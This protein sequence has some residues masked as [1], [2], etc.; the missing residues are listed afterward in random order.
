MQSKDK[1]RQRIMERYMQIVKAMSRRFDH[2][3]GNYASV[4]YHREVIQIIVEHMT[5]LE[6]VASMYDAN[7]DE[8]IA[9]DTR[10]EMQCDEWVIARE[11]EEMKKAPDFPARTGSNC[12]ICGKPTGGTTYCQMH[13][14]MMYA[15]GK[16]HGH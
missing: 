11:V 13:T 7:G 15:L 12:V 8:L 3:R 5:G 10:K 16:H 6:E 1:E 4:A 2:L 14:T 9:R